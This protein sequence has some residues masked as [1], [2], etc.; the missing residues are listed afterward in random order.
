MRRFRRRS[1]A[2][3]N[4]RST[5]E[6]GTEAASLSSHWAP[7]ILLTNFISQSAIFDKLC[8]LSKRPRQGADLAVKNAVDSQK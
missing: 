5:A 1:N 2:P 6:I 3:F 7:F 4:F 8:E